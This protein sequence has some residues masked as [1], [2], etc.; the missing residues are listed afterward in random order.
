MGPETSA[1]LQFGVGLGNDLWLAFLGGL[2]TSLTPCVYPLVPVTIALFGANAQ[3]GRVRSFFLSLTYV[4][5]IAVTY[6]SL[7]IFSAYTGVLFGQFLGNPWVVA[8]ICFF[9]LLLSLY[10][11]EVFTLDILYRVQTRASMVGGKGF[12]GAFAMGMASGFVAAPCAAPILIA[13]LG[14]AASTKNPLYGGTLLFVYALG[15][16]AIF[17]VLGTFSGLIKK[18]PKSGG[19]LHYVKFLIAA[20]LLMVALFLLQPFMRQA[21]VL[22]DGMQHAL[23]LIVFAI[24]SLYIATIGYRKNAKTLKAISAITF[25]FCAFHLAIPHNSGVEAGLEWLPSIEQGREQAQRDNRLMMVDFFAQWCAACKEFEAVTFLAPEV[26]ELLATFVLVRVDL[27]SF[28]EEND[29]IQEQYGLVGLPSLLFFSPQGSELSGT[30]IEGFLGPA[31]FTKHLEEIRQ[32][33]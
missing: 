27:T 4:L 10:T 3:A 19:W 17:V 31:E 13:I 28:S 33:K 20:A 8:A 5:G 7:G 12:G 32:R 6:S 24:L 26:K 16:G 14:L 1:A 29:R 23:L 22:F 11:L 9:L 21:G 30:R 18:L 25:A 15:F 2:T